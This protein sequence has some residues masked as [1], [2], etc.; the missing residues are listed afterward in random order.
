MGNVAVATATATNEKAIRAYNAFEKVKAFAVMKFRDAGIHPQD[1][2]DALQ[3][4]YLEVYDAIDG[5]APSKGKMITYLTPFINKVAFDSGSESSRYFNEMI[6]YLSKAVAKLGENAS[7]NDLA[8]EISSMYG[9]QI[10]AKTVRNTKAEASRKV[11]ILNTKGE[12]LP[13]VQNKV[14]SDNSDVIWECIENA[15]PKNIEERKVVSLWLQLIDEND[16]KKVTVDNVYRAYQQMSDDT[17]ITA[18]EFTYQ[19]RKFEDRFKRT[20]NVL[21]KRNNVK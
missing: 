3:D 13:E 7:D 10:S 16:Y 6:F 11:N 5:W 4:L 8:K 17:E 2:E 1:F 20:L 21:L 9:R 14:K 19:F 12:Y 18:E 15:L